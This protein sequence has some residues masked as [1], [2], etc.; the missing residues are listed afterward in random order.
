MKILVGST[1]PVKIEAVQTAFGS[2]FDEITVEGIKVG[3]EV[4]DQPINEETF[5]GA[6]NRAASLKEVNDAEGLGAE[7]FVGIE[8][9]IIELDTKWF[10]FGA[11]CIMNRD[12]KVGYG[13]SG[14]FPVPPTMTERLLAGEEMG[15]ITDEITG[16]E[17]TKHGEGFVGFLTQ[18]IINRTDFYT[19]G[20]IFALTPFLNDELYKTDNNQNL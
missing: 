15:E 17:N 14:H 13:T 11:M 19:P 20:I 4:P 7:Y 6:C 8:G 2:Y 16:E 10:A 9:G 12:G 1:N 18:G 5:E 3:S